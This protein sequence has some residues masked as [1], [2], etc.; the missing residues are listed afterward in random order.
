MQKG[1]KKIGIADHGPGHIL[2][3]VRRARFAEMRAEVDRLNGLYPGIEIALGLEANIINHSGRIDVSE[4]ENEFFDFILAGYHYGV[5]GEN[6]F[7]AISLAGRN[8]LGSLRGKYSGKL[9][10]ENTLLVEKALYESRIMALTHP[11]DKGKVDIKTIAEACVK[12]NVL[13]ELNTW[14]KSLD[15]D[16]VRTAAD[17]GV[18]F[19]ISSDAHSPNRVGDFESALELAFR[20]GIEPERIVNIKKTDEEE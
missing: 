11:G 15:D 3:G 4:R 1:L 2:Y 14:H 19:V 6:P 17:C 12:N 20:V 16:S 5:L 9:I 18:S 8:Y 10:L 7:Y 13:F